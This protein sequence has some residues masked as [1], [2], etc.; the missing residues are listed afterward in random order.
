MAPVVHGVVHIQ[1]MCVTDCVSLSGVIPTHPGQNDEP[2]APA[3][4]TS[5]KAGPGVCQPRA[6]SFIPAKG[7][8]IPH[9][10][11]TH[12][13]RPW[14]GRF[15]PKWGEPLQLIRVLILQFML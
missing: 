6:G 10:T 13:G 14:Q 4:T 7:I 9:P 12:H 5:K 8:G 11:K 2:R 3:S 15:P 1:L